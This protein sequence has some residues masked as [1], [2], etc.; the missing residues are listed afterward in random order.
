MFNVVL[1][2]LLGGLSLKGLASRGGPPKTKKKLAHSANTPSCHIVA[3]GSGRT[4]RDAPTGPGHGTSLTVS[5]SL[6]G[7]DLGFVGRVRR[8]GTGPNLA[9]PSEPARAF[10]GLA[11]IRLR[12]F[13]FGRKGTACRKEAKTASASGRPRDAGIEILSTVNSSSKRRQGT[14]RPADLDL[15]PKAGHMQGGESM[16]ISGLRT[17]RPRAW[18]LAIA[19]TTSGRTEGWLW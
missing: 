1:L 18:L 3:A 4:G 15:G 11:S 5:R 9:L 13:L 7:R 17:T 16:P 2:W 6:G 10:T 19:E 12:P 14:R 8:S